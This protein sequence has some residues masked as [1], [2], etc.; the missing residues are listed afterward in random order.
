MV[1][2]VTLLWLEAVMVIWF[3]TRRPS[4]FYS[5][6]CCLE[7]VRLYAVAGGCRPFYYLLLE[8]G[9]LSLCPNR[10][11]VIYCE[12]R[13]VMV[14]CF[15]CFTAR[16][17]SSS[18]FLL[19]A[20]GGWLHVTLHGPIRCHLLKAGHMP[21]RMCCCK[22]SLPFLDLPFKLFPFVRQSLWHV[23]LKLC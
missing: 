14:L 5:L 10:F 19:F 18:Y 1:L 2:P 20:A 15:C 9:Y 11:Y 17:P 22:K 7:A 13:A 6:T 3:C 4:L 16:R 12:W 8:V 23:A 21:L